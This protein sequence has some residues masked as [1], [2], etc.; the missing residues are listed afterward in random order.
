[1]LKIKGPFDLKQ[2]WIQN[3]YREMLNKQKK[4]KNEGKNVFLF[5]GFIIFCCLVLGVFEQFLR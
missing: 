1:M 5:I 2:R 3:I 4:E